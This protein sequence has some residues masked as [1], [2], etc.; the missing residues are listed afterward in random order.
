[1]I[2]AIFLLLIVLLFSVPKLLG[3]DKIEYKDFYN[4]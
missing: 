4:F 1:M 2:L 3:Y